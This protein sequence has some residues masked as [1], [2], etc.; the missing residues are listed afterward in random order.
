VLKGTTQKNSIIN[1][2]KKTKEKQAT[3][4]CSIF[5]RYSKECKGEITG[6]TS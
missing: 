1:K 3:N 2:P 6:K 5:A 4:A